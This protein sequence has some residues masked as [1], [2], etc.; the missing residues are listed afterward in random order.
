MKKHILIL[1]A[2]ALAVF[3]AAAAPAAL[4]AEEYS[5]DDLYRIAL[6]R[7]EKLKVAEENLSI[8][9]LGRDKA[10]SY[11]LPRLTAT[12]GVTQYSEKKLS[13]TGSVIQAESA[14]SWGVRLD[15]TVSLSGRELTAL[16][17]SRQNV[18]R[19]QY[20]LTAIREDYLLRYVAAAYYNVLMSRKNLEI[21][22]SNL[23]RLQKYREAAEKR[24]R[25]GEVTKT[26]LLRA[27]GELSG[28][29]SDR[30]QAL[31]SLELATAVLASNVGVRDAFTLREETATQGDIPALGVFQEQAFAVRADLK[32]LEIQ[33]QIAADQIRYAEGAFWP[34]LSVSGV[35]NGT[36]Q[37]PGSTTLNRESIYGGVALNFPFFEGGLRKA[38]LSEAKARERQA[39]L[40]YEDA[41]K[42]IEI[43]V[44][45][46][47][48]D[49]VTQ[50]GILKF[51]NDQL[52]FARDNYHAVAR[53][54][55]FGL[56]SS[57]DVLDANALLVS[58]ERKAASADYNYRL[59]QLRMKKATGTLL[60]TAAPKP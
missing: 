44:Q 56:S 33:K 27:E 47:Y 9:E 2:G 4:W 34:S 42:G 46:A 25:V 50:K 22:D 5:L 10:L 48:L 1:A 57:L 43:E 53:Q 32:S 14:S 37:T 23:D 38:E 6:A 30:L 7:S 19:S 18:T 40:F 12:G 55:D 31:N 28:A 39:V 3:L 52:A 49:L 51:L 35:Y 59:A 11:L 20:D 17:I 41:K 29:K 16:G 24:L 26:A 8:S 54:F 36:D 15:E 45:S 60:A 58:A 13:T 21:A